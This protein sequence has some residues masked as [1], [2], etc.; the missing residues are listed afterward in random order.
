MKTTYGLSPKSATKTSPTHQDYLGYLTQKQL[1]QLNKYKKEQ[2][3]DKD[4]FVSGHSNRGRRMK[5][6]HV[7]EDLKL[8]CVNFHEM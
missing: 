4:S 5:L 1:L 8:V 3:S 7:M 2:E 6:R